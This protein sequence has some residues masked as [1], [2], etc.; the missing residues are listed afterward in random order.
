MSSFVCSFGINNGMRPSYVYDSSY[1]KKI[2]VRE[3]SLWTS[4]LHRCFSQEKLQDNP[5]YKDCLVSDNF[6]NYTYFYDWCQNQIGFGK[7]G[8][9]LDKDILSESNKIYSETTCAFI[10]QEINKFF[11]N[12]VNDRGNYPVGVTLDK[13][14]NKFQARCK[15]ESCRKHLGYFVS[16]DE[17][18]LAY[19]TFKEVMCKQ[20]ALKWQHEIDPRVFEAM[21]KWEVD[22]ND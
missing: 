21:M 22:R 14:K 18:F 4:M 16:F 17:A 2:K 10:P 12:R 20:L 11:T 13:V 19:K 6:L 1:S 15:T 8:W 3:Y 5:T 7:Q 9:Q